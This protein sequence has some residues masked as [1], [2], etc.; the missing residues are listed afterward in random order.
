MGERPAG[1]LK[2]DP[3][4]IECRW[5][6]SGGRLGRGVS[7]THRCRRNRLNFK[8]GEDTGGGRGN[9]FLNQW[10][11]WENGRKSVK[12]LPQVAVMGLANREE[13]E[14]RCRAQSQGWILCSGCKPLVKLDLAELYD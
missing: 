1:N 8:V 13:G 9:M 12:E 3:W 10:R 5:K 14:D 4:N 6:A 2:C 11:P 7:V